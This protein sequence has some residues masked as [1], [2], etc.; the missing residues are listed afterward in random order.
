MQEAVATDD[1]LLREV[2]EIERH[3]RLIR[4][5]THRVIED[6]QRRMPL[7]LRSPGTE[8]GTR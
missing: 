7:T 3:L 8:L 6:D 4:R 1:E 5:E 2:E